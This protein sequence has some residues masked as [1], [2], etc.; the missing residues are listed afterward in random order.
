MIEQRNF[1]CTFLSFKVYKAD[2]FNSDTPHYHTMSQTRWSA[3][4]DHFVE[5]GNSFRCIVLKSDGIL[6][7]NS[8]VPKLKQGSASANLKRHLKRHHQQTFQK[9][10]QQD[11]A[12]TKKA[13][14]EKVKGQNAVTNYFQKVNPNPK[15]TASINAEDF[16]NGILKMVVYNGVPLTFFQDDGFQLLN[17]DFAKILGISLGRQAIRNMVLKRS[18]EERSKLKGS[19]SKTFVSLKF[20]GVTRLRS[21][22]LGISAQFFSEKRGLSVKTLALVDTEANHTSAHLKEILLKTMKEFSITKQQVLACVV[23]NASNM[24]RTVQLLNEDEEDEQN[25]DDEEAIQEIDQMGTGFDC[26]I[27]HMR[28]AEHTLQLGIRDVLKKGR[29]DKFLTKLRKIAQ[30]LRAPHT[31]GILKRRAGKGMLIDMPTRWGST[32]LMLQ[33]LLDLKSFIQD[34]GSQDS[35][36]TE[37]EWS[38]VKM[39]VDVLQI[40]HAAIISLQKQDLT[41]GECLLQWREV[42]FKLNK[43]DNSLSRSL[44][45]SLLSRQQLLLDNDAFLAAIWVSAK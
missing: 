14:L 17:G 11:S 15:A 12:T 5:E 38:E 18:E 3:V 31:D 26:T 2:I 30:H 13:K 45:N 24:T 19:L 10:E 20:D 7:C 39:M 8:L 36:L 34:L 32:F 4:Y 40:P 42:M 33:R 27:Y 16:K 29:S 44:H 23:D 1:I 35:Y 22:F 6:E 28:C 43:Q 37:S 21:H 41:P 9:V 25:E